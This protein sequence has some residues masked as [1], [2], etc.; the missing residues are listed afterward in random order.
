VEIGSD[1][2]DVLAQA[3]GLLGGAGELL[4]VTAAAKDRTFAFED[5]GPIAA[6]PGLLNR[7]LQF[8]PEA[9]VDGVRRT[10]P[11]QSQ[12]PYPVLRDVLDPAWRLAGVDGV[13]RSQR[14]VNCGVRLAFIAAT[15]SR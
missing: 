9:H 2:S 4:Q 12:T 6:V 11:D 1:I 15:A 5:D 3:A 13:T 14:P 8:V 10:G 7:E